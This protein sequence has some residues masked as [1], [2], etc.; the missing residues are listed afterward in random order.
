MIA[1]TAIMASDSRDLPG[2]GIVIIMYFFVM[3]LMVATKHYTNT[4]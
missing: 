2:V 1:S 3:S 4:L